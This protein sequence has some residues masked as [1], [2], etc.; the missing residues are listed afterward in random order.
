[1]KGRVLLELK[2]RKLSAANLNRRKRRSRIQTGVCGERDKDCF[3]ARIKRFYASSVD[4]VNPWISNVFCLVIR[5]YPKGNGNGINHR[6][7]FSRCSSCR[8]KFRVGD[9]KPANIWRT[10]LGFGGLDIFLANI[11]D[12]VAYTGRTIGGCHGVVVV[13]WRRLQM[14]GDKRHNWSL[15]TASDRTVIDLLLRKMGQPSNN[16]DMYFQGESGMQE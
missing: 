12:C 6:F 11:L 2:K 15:D 9:A 13:L 4:E 7:Q 5:G 16:H 3:T 10:A 1:M 8:R 14:F